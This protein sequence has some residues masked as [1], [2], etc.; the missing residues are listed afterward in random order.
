VGTSISQRSPNTP[1]W[2]AVQAT[3][4]AAVP[5]D[6]VTQEVWRAASHDVAAG[7]QQLLASPAVFQCYVLAA[8]ADNGPAAVARASRA[9]SQSSVSTVGTE[10]AKRAV[11]L[12]AGHPDPQE[13]FAQALFRQATDYIVS[14][15]L[16][17]FIG[18]RYRNATVADS[19]EFKGRV[20]EHVGR[21]VRAVGVPEGADGWPSYVQ[22]VITAL[23][24]S[25]HD[26]G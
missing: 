11:A 3:Y 10:L 16:A 14:R 5:V 12:S 21:V 6:R 4:R 22:A 26:E 23:R 1:S 13:R 25:R 18:P 24:T 9:L 17:G 8:S 19:T 15:D 2:R 20:G 7:W